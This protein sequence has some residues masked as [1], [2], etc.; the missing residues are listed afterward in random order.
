M[1]SIPGNSKRLIVLIKF[2]SNIKILKWQKR[3][4]NF[5][6]HFF[7]NLFFIQITV[8]QKYY[9]IFI[10]KHFLQKQQNIL[11]V[12]KTIWKPLIVC[13]CGVLFLLTFIVRNTITYALHVIKSFE[14]METKVHN[15]TIQ[16]I[17][18]TSY[19]IDQ[20]VNHTMSLYMN[21][22]LFLYMNLMKRYSV[23]SS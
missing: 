6:L 5:S 15:N 17:W 11:I 19:S 3:K 23:M 16:Y 22:S 12:V 2:M 1:T 10:S 4:K 8:V 14:S 21:T 20:G 13:E 7:F 9:K 18:S